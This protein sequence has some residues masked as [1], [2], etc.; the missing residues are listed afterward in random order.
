MKETEKFLSRQ[1]YLTGVV[2]PEQIMS[3]YFKELGRKGGSSVSP[4]KRAA[5]KRNIAKATR[6]RM[7]KRQQQKYEL[8]RMN[9][10]EKT[11]L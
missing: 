5:S 8:R 2:T 4:K 10:S 6:D 3:D 9:K 11:E 7:K 1:M